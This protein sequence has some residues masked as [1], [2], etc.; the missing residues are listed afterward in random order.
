VQ[1]IAVDDKIEGTGTQTLTMINSSFDGRG[2]WCVAEAG[3][4]HSGIV[5]V[6]VCSNGVTLF[7]IGSIRSRFMCA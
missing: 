3:R 7:D 5:E 1:I 6:G 4:A 2:Y